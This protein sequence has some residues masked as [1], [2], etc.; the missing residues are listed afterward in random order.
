MLKKLISGGDAGIERAVLDVGLALGMEIGG[1]YTAQW[2][3]PK[4]GLFRIATVL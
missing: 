2:A 3:T 4:A 1:W